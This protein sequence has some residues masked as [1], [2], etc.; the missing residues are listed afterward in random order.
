VARLLQ[1]IF[2]QQSR[3][4]H[5]IFLAFVWLL[6]LNCGIA[7]FRM[8]QTTSFSLMHGVFDCSVSI[9][10]LLSVSLLPFLFSAF[11]VYIRSYLFLVVLCFIKS[12]LFAF[13]SMGLICTYTSAGWLIRLLMM[14]SDICSLVPLWWCWIRSSSNV[15]FDSYRSVVIASFA[16]VIIS[17]LDYYL[18]SPILVK[19]LEF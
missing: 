2:P 4:Y 11:A 3:K 16:A 5:N 19:L 13:V 6:G 15:P 10:G 14:F 17:C 9:V 1:W 18:V 8:S 7:L 12:C